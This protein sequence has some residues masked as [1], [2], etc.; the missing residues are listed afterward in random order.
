MDNHELYHHGV[1][2]MKWGVRKDR[3][4]NSSGRSSKQQTPILSKNGE[5]VNLHQNP[6]SATAKFLAKLIPSIT[7]KQ[8]NFRDYTI[9]AKDGTKVGNISTNR[10][11]RESLNI[12]WLGISSK[13]EGRGYGQ[14]AMRTII[15]DA[16]KQG[17]KNVTLEVPTTSPNAR[18]IYE[19]I[20]FKE[21]GEAML[22][23][24]NDV[25]GGLTKMRLDL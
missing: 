19:K 18:H 11:S 2:G 9:R 22:G 4:R 16:K 3:K 14:S 21:T 12:I 6:Q 10:D 20:G 1:K 15:D 17:F 7:E 13:Y 24:E 8:K 5:S 25:W 23:D